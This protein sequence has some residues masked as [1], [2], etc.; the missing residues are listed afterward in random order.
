MEYFNSNDPVKDKI[1]NDVI[2][3]CKYDIIHRLNQTGNTF[4]VGWKNDS[5]IAFNVKKN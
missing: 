3:K 5:I 4:I 1:S 2:V